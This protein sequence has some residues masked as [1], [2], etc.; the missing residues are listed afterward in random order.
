M[1]VLHVGA[2]VAVEGDDAVPGEGDGFHAVVHGVKEHHGAHAQHL[3]YL[4]LILQVGVLLLDD[5]GHALPGLVQ[6][7][8][9]EDDVALAGAHLPFGQFHHA[10][11]R[12]QHPTF[13]PR[14]H[15]VQHGEDLLEVQYLVRAH[16]VETAVEAIG[17]L[18][19]Q[20]R[21]Q[22]AGGVDAG[23]ITLLDE[24]GRNDTHVFQI[25]NAGALVAFHQQARVGEPLQRGHE[26]I[27]VEGLALLQGVEAHAQAIV[28][29]LELRERQITE[30]LP[31]FPR[32]WI[33]VLQPLKPVAGLVAH[34]RIALLLGVE[35]HVE[36][37]EPEQGRAAL[38]GGRFG[39]VEVLFQIRIPILGPAGVGRQ[40]RTELGAPVPQVVEADHLVAQELMGLGQG[41]ADHGRAQ[42]ADGEQLGDVRRAV[43]DDHL[44]AVGRTRAVGPVQGCF[45]DGPQHS[46][47]TG[48]RRE[49]Q[50]QVGTGCHQRPAFDGDGSGQFL[51]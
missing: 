19:I 18:A 11:G 47:G 17:R 21:S 23:A 22:V 4:G 44:L 13:E 14:V 31:E 2:G 51:R 32:P 45:E 10:E 25:D 40:Q 34:G 28:D 9:Q 1:G 35:T 41:M 48:F 26:L 3:G 15:L 46:L 30:P 12:V 8:L 33:V 27:L 49:L 29:A 5:G 20:R 16:H 42:M 7:V 50:I 6:H 39:P 38:L 43:L 36:L 24:T 37:E